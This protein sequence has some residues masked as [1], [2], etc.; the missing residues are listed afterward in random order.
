[1][2]N[3]VEEHSIALN[4]LD[5]G[6]AWRVYR[7]GLPALLDLYARYD[8]E[9]TFYFTGTFA[10][11]IPDSIDLVKDHGHEIGCHGYLHEV[12]RAFDVLSY[13][14]QVR[15]LTLAKKAI[16]TQ[17]GTIEAFRAPAAR[18]NQHTVRALEV[19]GYLTDSS[20]SPQR[21]DGPLSFGGW[22][23][24][25]WLFAHRL[26]YHLNHD[27]PFQP[28]NSTILEIPISALL[29]AYIG[30]T[31]RVAPNLNRLLGK[32]LFRESRKRSMKPIV[33]LFHPVEVIEVKEK[34]ETTRRVKS[35]LGYLFG[36]VIRQQ[37]KLNNLGKNALK[38][39]EEVLKEAKARDFEFV[40]A[41]RFR[42]IFEKHDSEVG[43]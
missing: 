12:D 2:T 33:F 24:I 30:T 16:E 14:E 40:S 4:K 23:K 37:L 8:V 13:E 9:G 6:T 5:E 26:P 7:E 29:F 27:N 34:I 36:D 17:A 3:D 28:G 38:L 10:E 18:I 1:M 32:L 22:N 11:M 19:T 21:F 20:V 31:M 35:R 39:S 25:N 42:K 43:R 15:D 41:H